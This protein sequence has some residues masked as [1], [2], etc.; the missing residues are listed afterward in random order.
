[1]RK[2]KSS[3]FVVSKKLMPSI[4]KVEKGFILNHNY[5]ILDKETGKT[6]VEPTLWDERFKVGDEVNAPIEFGIE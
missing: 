3:R 2:E 5:L 6:Y 1:M 4:V